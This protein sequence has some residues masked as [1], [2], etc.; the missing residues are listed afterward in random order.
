MGTDGFGRSD[1]RKNLR[2]FFEVD[3]PHI[4][5]STIYSLYE[6]EKV[7]VEMVKKV[8]K[9]YNFKTNSDDPWKI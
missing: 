8:I 5:L 3:S 6:E 4:V 1:T 2:D 9:K 7:S